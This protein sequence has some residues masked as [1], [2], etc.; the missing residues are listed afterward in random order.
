MKKPEPSDFNLTQEEV[1]R[2]RQVNDEA[3]WVSQCF[4]SVAAYVA[5]LIALW[6]EIGWPGA[7]LAIPSALILGSLVGAG[8]SHLALRLYCGDYSRYVSAQ[9]KYENWFVKT[10]KSF[11]QGLDGRAFEREVASLLQKTGRTTQLTPATGDKGVD[12]ILEDGTLVQCKA[13]KSPVGPAVARELYGTM[14]HFKA[15]RGLLISRSGFTGG[16]RQF[17]RGKPI[18]LWDLGCLIGLQKDLDY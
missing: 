5:L 17:V 18:L 12:I 1:K 11:W 14:R 6:R 7:A 4:C 2:L 13:H 9:K 16:V 10:Q 3:V 15:R 8:I